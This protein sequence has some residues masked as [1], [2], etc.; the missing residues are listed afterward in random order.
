MPGRT[1]WRRA[2]SSEYNG[3][4]LG[5]SGRGPIS[6]MSPFSTLMSCGS[7][8]M[9][10][11]RTNLP[12]VVRRCASGSSLPFSSRSS[13]MVLNLMTLKILPS[14]PGRSWKK[15]SLPQTPPSREGFPFL[16]A[17]KSQIDITN[18]M[19]LMQISAMSEIQKS[20]NRLKKCLYTEKYKYR[21]IEEG[22]IPK[23]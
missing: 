6:A 19:G 15:K 21:K 13:V 9:L 7:S 12:T 22:H 16:S 8:S 18:R 3:K 11:E 4:Y 1:S 5:S 2:C 20:R 23:E 10:V 14:L 17:I